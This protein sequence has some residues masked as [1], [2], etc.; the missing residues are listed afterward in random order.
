MP[1]SEK[2]RQRSLLVCLG[3]MS[4]FGAGALVSISVAWALAVAA[5]FV[6]SAT[7]MFAARK[8]VVR[9]SLTYFLGFILVISAS[10]QVISQFDVNVGAAYSIG[11]RVLGVSLMAFAA[12]QSVQ[13]FEG[14]KD[15]T[16]L[17]KQWIIALVLPVFFYVVF[18]TVPHG[19]WL[20]FFSYSLG[21]GLLTLS[22][23]VTGR[24][25]SQIL[26]RS[27]VACLVVVV[28][29]SLLSGALTPAD[30]IEGDRLRGLL[31]NANGLGFFSFLLG[32]ISLLVIRRGWLQVFL[33][34]VAAVSLIWTASRASA[35]ALLLLVLFV[36]IRDKKI[37]ILLVSASLIG[38]VLVLTLP[39]PQLFSFLEPIFRDN[40]SREGSLGIAINSLSTH[41]I[42]GVGFG[43]EPGNVAS[44]PLRAAV[45]AG[46][47][48][49]VIV[50][51]LYV[52]I[53]VLSANQGH[54]T[55]AFAG[56]AMVHSLF[57]AWLLSPVGPIILA[58]SVCWIVVANR[59]SDEVF[60]AK[61][62]GTMSGVVVPANRNNS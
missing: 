26:V 23:V 22:I 42:A 39:Q 41:P 13:L 9:I 19:L 16:T 48:G 30:A 40:N 47:I 44:T 50:F 43:Q 6:V 32:A 18:S 57:E 3:S 58:F 38:I 25:P 56:A 7:L 12:M 15:R 21:A 10:A 62:L 5:V 34:L 31:E 2:A 36:S 24:V 11:A 8:V 60:G 28:I 27:V 54:K 61:S 45:V 55:F 1:V 59:E 52:G 29:G 4:A 14:G 17:S 51:V 49:L 33:F 35:L 53:L 20:E 37:R 46:V